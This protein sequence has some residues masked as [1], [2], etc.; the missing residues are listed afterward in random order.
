MKWAAAAT[1]M[2]C[3][4]LWRFGRASHWS[5]ATAKLWGALVAVATTGGLLPKS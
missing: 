4:M 3:V 2:G 1:I 5:V